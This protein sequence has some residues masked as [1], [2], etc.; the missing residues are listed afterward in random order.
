MTIK[1]NELK[2]GNKIYTTRYSTMWNRMVE[3]PCTI[4]EVTEINGNFSIMAIA[5]DGF[6]K[7]VVDIFATPETEY[8]AA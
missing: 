6:K 8:K 5:Q 2:Q 4:M 1:A 3:M 7:F